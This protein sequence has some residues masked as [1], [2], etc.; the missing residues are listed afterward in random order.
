MADT[1]TNICQRK[2]LMP[3]ARVSSTTHNAM[4]IFLS[5][6]PIAGGSLFKEL[7]KR[8]IANV[9]WLK[10]KKM[11]SITRKTFINCPA[12]GSSSLAC[13]KKFLNRGEKSPKAILS[14]RFQRFKG[15]VRN[16][17]DLLSWLFFSSL[18]PGS[19]IK[20]DF[21]KLEVKKAKNIKKRLWIRTAQE[22]ALQENFRFNPKYL[23]KAKSHHY[24]WFDLLS[25]TT[26]QCP[27]PIP[28]V[29]DPK[30]RL[31]LV[32]WLFILN[33]N[34][35]HHPPLCATATRCTHTRVIVDILPNF[36]FHRH[37]H[38]KQQ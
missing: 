9:H 37:D 35:Q 34:P 24:N 10:Y 29:S 7:H 14:Q 3:A 4:E 12:L 6:L 5:S 25:D 15:G 36:R 33:H 32:G 31:P 20:G 21:V 23:V 26:R 2:N 30:P 38:Q 16:I 28:Q 19:S 1:N 18:H 13:C 22:K 11:C 17:I 27:L 8:K